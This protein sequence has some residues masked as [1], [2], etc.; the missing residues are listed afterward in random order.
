[1][2]L[3]ENNESEYKYV[4]CYCQ[5]R[6][7]HCSKRCIL[8]KLLDRDAVY[9]EE[10]LL[11]LVCSIAAVYFLYSSYNYFENAYNIQTKKN[12]CEFYD[13]FLFLYKN[14]QDFTNFVK[15]VSGHFC[16]TYLGLGYLEYYGPGDRSFRYIGPGNFFREFLHDNFGHADFGPGYCHGMR[17]CHELNGLDSFEKLSQGFLSLTFAAVMAVIPIFRCYYSRR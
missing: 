12:M 2:N 13:N 5:V 6:H 10:K 8:P 17:Y 11:L 15:N 3:I 7:Q 1:M 16:F 14:N 4:E 9:P